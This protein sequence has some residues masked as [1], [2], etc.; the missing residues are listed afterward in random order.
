M[1]CADLTSN[2]YIRLTLFKIK[3]QQTQKTRSACNCRLYALKPHVCDANLF[4]NFFCIFFCGGLWQTTSYE[5]YCRHLLSGVK[6]GKNIL[7]L[8]KTSTKMHSLT[9]KCTQI[10]TQAL[11]PC[12]GG[13]QLVSIPC[14]VFF[15]NYYYSFGQ[16]NLSLG[17]Y[18]QRNEPSLTP[19][20]SG[21]RASTASAICTAS[22]KETCVTDLDPCYYSEALNP[23][24]IAAPCCSSS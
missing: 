11:G 20:F 6:T 14:N 19:S 10:P 21:C 12:E 16:Y 4:L 5:V 2:H 24:T 7:M 23:T 8:K 1:D 17:Q 22:A 13:T 3:A 15:F 18:K 9:Q